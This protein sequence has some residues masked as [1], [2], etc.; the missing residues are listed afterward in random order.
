MAAKF[1]TSGLRGL[2]T[3]LIGGTAAAHVTAFARRMIAS[4][5]V[6]PG[7]A[8]H[9]G[10]DHRASS[11]TLLKETADALAAAG[12]SPVDCGHLPTPALALHAMTRRNA[13]VMV[14]GSHIPADRNGIKFYRPDGEIDKE[15]EAAMVADAARMASAPAPAGGESASRT[16]QQAEAMAAYRARYRGLAPADALNGWRIG[17]WQHSSVARDFLMELVALFGGEAVAL[18]R[19]TTFVPIDTEAVD[20]GALER[21]AGHARDLALNAV[22][23]TDADA[24]RPLVL[25]AAGRQ[26]RGDTLG[27][28]TARLLAA[29]AIA[30]PVTSNSGAA[31][32]TGASVFTTKVGSPFVIAA[33][34]AAIRNGSRRVA[35]FE[36]NGG[37]LCGTDMSL[38]DAPLPA[39]MTRDSTLPILACL[40]EGRRAGSVSAL[41]GSLG[42]PTALGDRITDVPTEKGMALVARLTADAAA[43][44]AFL[45]GIGT[46]RA[47][48]L[49]DG[50][51]IH[52][53]SGVIVHLRPSGNAPEMRFYVE[54]VDEERARSLL[55]DGTRRLVDA[56]RAMA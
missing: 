35:G 27:I 28:I 52:L 19:S 30:C 49:T 5:H 8:V 42:L 39:L 10:C 16:S 11:P 50:L 43:R 37:F 56:L 14:T 12:L 20:A 48:D 31:R 6:R 51:R 25:D 2:A 3:E 46:S 23:S 54:A 1:G 13:A 38:N 47:I 9:L 32:A 34:E 44:D 7:D 36:P 18:E 4:G 40:L 55:Q 15:D 29:D 22:I 21:L 26:V 41:V 45:S 53:D 24:D 33:M 17:V